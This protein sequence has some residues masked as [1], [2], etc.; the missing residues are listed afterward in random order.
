MFYSLVQQYAEIVES[1]QVTTFKQFGSARSLIAH[2]EFIDRS[3]LHIKDY[4]F[5]DGTRKYSYHWQSTDGELRAR[6]DNSPHHEL[7]ATFPHHKHKPDGVSSSSERAL[8]DI[9]EHIQRIL[10]Q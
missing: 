2:I 7:I 10:T 3:V 4:L 8:Q 1:Y 9:L 6:W 5:L